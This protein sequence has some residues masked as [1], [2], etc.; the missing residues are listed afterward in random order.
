MHALQPPKFENRR[1]TKRNR[2]SLRTILAR[3]AQADKT[4]PPR[5]QLAKIRS[6]F[7][8]TCFSR[9]AVSTPAGRY[10]GSAIPQP[11]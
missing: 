11:R 5:L 10:A 2:C 8:A 7:P 4:N 9:S 1:G 3:V 6:S